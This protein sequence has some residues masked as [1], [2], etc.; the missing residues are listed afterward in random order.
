MTAYGEYITLF[1]LDHLLY[2]GGLI[3]LGTALFL[4]K[5][6]IKEKKETI[7]TLIIL[8]SIGQQIL[9]YSSYFYLFDFDLAES[10]PLHI[11]RINSLLGMW[12]LLTKNKAVF[13]VL[14]FFGLYAWTSFLYPSR[15]YGV[16]H[17]IGISF[18]VNHVITLLLPYYGMI[19]YGERVEKGDKKTAFFWF[20][21]YLV[22]AIS[23]NH[24]VDGNY[25]YLKHKPIFAFLPDAIYIPLL[26]LFTY[27]FFTLGY[28]LYTKI[29]YALDKESIQLKNSK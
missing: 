20:L 2:I 3:G 25:F 14:C 27:L 23:V 15:V 10:L 9:L 12:Y 1:N 18:F 5:Q 4:N 21:I 7:S 26:V 17:P 29:Q 28:Y 11:S 22:T 13:K 24:L 16:F 8:F 6:T 19:V